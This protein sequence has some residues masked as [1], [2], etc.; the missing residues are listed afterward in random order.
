M[1]EK[2][3]LNDYHQRVRE[4]IGSELKQRGL[5]D[6]NDWLYQETVPLPL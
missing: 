2:T 3:W 4:V 1:G 5:S 6:V